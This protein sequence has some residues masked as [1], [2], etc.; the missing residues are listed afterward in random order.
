MKKFLLSITAL[1]LIFVLFTGCSL[2]KQEPAGQGTE[3]NPST[4]NSPSTEEKPK[5][6]QTVQSENSSLSMDFPKSWKE[7]NLNDIATIQMAA[8][9]KEQYMIV[10]EES[11]L[12]FDESFTLDDYTAIIVENMKAGVEGAE[13]PIL[14]DI[15]VGSSVPAKQFELTGTVDKIKVKYLI[16]CIENN[17]VFYQVITWSLQSRYDEAKP[18]F[19]EILTSVTF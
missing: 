2:I 14:S 1:I 15:T 9:L 5:D 18:V 13:E 3:N 7:T 17:G 10:I 4:E 12:D 8:V 16:T 11:A 19:D 6:I